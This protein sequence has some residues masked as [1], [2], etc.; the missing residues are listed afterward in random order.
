MNVSGQFVIMFND[1]PEEVCAPGTTQAQ[2][3]ARANQ[4][5]EEYIKRNGSTVRAS[6]L[7]IR[8]MLVTV[9]TP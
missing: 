1:Y 7:H 9:Y 8:P 2:A 5:K 3:D 4:I 6:M